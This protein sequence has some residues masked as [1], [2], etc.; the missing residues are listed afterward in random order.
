MKHRHTFYSYATPIILAIFSLIFTSWLRTE[1]YLMVF[2][3]LSG[4][5]YTFILKGDKVYKYLKDLTV[6]AFIYSLILGIIFA[7]TQFEANW[8]FIYD[9]G[10][11]ALLLIPFFIFLLSGGLGIVFKGLYSL[12]TKIIDR[13]IIFIAPTILIGLSFFVKN[14][15]LSI[16]VIIYNYL[17]FLALSTFV[18]FIIQLLNKY[19]KK[20]KLNPTPIIFI[21]TLIV[22]AIL[23]MSP[24]LKR[25]YI[26]NEIYK[27]SYCKVDSDCQALEPK[28]PFGCA[29]YVNKENADRI[30]EL[31]KSYDSNCVYSCIE[32][33]PS[34]ENNRCQYVTK[35]QTK[36][37]I[38]S[39]IFSNNDPDIII[40]ELQ[41]NIND[42]SD[43]KF[44]DKTQATENKWLFDSQWWI[45]D[46][47]WNILD[48]NASSIASANSLSENQYGYSDIPSSKAQELTKELSA[49]FLDN[50][51]VLNENNT[52]DLENEKDFYDFITAFQKNET[53]CTLTLNKDNG[54]YII[55]CSDNFQKAYNEQIPYLKGLDI[56]NM[57]AVRINRIGDYAKV[58][59]GLRRTGHFKIIKI[60]GNKMEEIFGGQEYPSCELMDKYK[61]PKEIYENCYLDKDGYNIRF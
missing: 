50:S 61:I 10:F 21:F 44:I 8:K 7:R 13:I 15:H 14:N 34:C 32:T 57:V 9:P 51:F 31:L 58:D 55:T 20:L 42:S 60:D 11:Y 3:V 12:Y 37:N 38:K 16:K 52:S 26:K 18:F 30:S 49:I 46:D 56:R 22:G 6:G 41:K 36:L 40:K 1:A 24:G 47:G 33:R 2:L 5:L 4:I 25:S 29:I 17:I 48:K 19:V 27:A 53:R 59:F 28:C 54:L 43:I 35:D 45:S 23:L 39:F